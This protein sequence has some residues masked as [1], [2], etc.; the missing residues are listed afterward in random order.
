MPFYA[1]NDLV[2][3]KRLEEDNSKAG[4]F[5][6]PEKF[7]QQSDLGVVVSIGHKVTGPIQAG[8]IVKFGAYN[9]ENLKDDGQ[10]YLLIREGDI[11]GIKR[12]DL[13]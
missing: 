7:R 3:V 13:D 1:Y 8:D 11:R 10:S 12:L 2:Q 4:P 9:A 5:V 6:I